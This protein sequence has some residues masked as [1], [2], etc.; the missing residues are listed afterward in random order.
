VVIFR[1]VSRAAARDAK[2]VVERIAVKAAHALG[3]IAER[4]AH[5]EHVVI[6]R[7]IADGCEVEARLILPVTRAK[8]GAGG[9]Q[10]VA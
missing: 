1:A 5:V 10:L 8:L 7:E 3:Q 2:V 4:E 6:E 9:L